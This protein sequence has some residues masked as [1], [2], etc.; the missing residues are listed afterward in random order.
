MTKATTKRTTQE[1]TADILLDEERMRV[2]EREERRL[3]ELDAV[4][5]ACTR[6][7]EVDGEKGTCSDKLNVHDPCSKCPCPAYRGPDGEGAA[8]MAE[9]IT[10]KHRT[11]FEPT[12]PRAKR[13]TAKDTQ[14][15]P[16]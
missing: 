12:T 1:L 11:L 6:E 16:N 4:S 7:Y 13:G 10:A 15:K 9:K 3:A 14:P 5:P 8:E 2:R